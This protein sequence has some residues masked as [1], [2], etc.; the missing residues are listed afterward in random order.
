MRSYTCSID[1]SALISPYAHSFKCPILFLYTNIRICLHRLFFYSL[2][3]F[4]PRHLFFGAS[5]TWY[6]DGAGQPAVDHGAA[7]QSFSRS[8]SKLAE[9]SL[10]GSTGSSRHART[11]TNDVCVSVRLQ[12]GGGVFLLCLSGCAFF[13][14]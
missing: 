9:A 6:V 2:A 12:L 5:T 13:F 10:P 11:A 8:D 3:R 4:S 14:L 1:H 7:G